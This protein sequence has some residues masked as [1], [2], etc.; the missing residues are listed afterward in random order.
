MLHVSRINSPEALAALAADWN[1]LA[2]GHPFR[3]H[4][5]HATWWQHYA[6]GRR[7][8]FV[9]VVRDDRGTVVGIAPWCIDPSTT[10]GR[11]ITWLGSGEVCS[12]YQSLLVSPDHVEGVTDAIAEWL[13]SAAN[14]AAGDRWDL[15]QLD[16]VEAID[17]AVARLVSHLWSSGS[18]VYREAG[19]NCWRIELPS[20]WDEYVEALS[21]SHRKQL[22]RLESRDL[23]T[24]RAVL[25]TASDAG[26]L[27]R[28]MNILIDLHQRRRTS[29]GQP[30][31]F[32]SQPFT[33]FLHD[34]A[35]RLFATNMLRLHWL[36]IAGVPAAAEF[37]LAGGAVTYAYQAG[38]N[39]DLLDDEPGRL[40][41][42]ATLRH[43]I[44]EGCTGFDFLRGD[45]PYKAHWRALAC[46]TVVYRIVP[47]RT[48]SQIR[49]GV[50]LAGDSV[51]SWV[52][53]GLELTGMR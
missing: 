37:Q 28:G 19:S 27:A 22:R 45:E 38:V 39:P 23:Q 24:G 20:S 15:L 6:D 30:G 51:K 52:K 2:G 18:T 36:E 10:R 41:N 48:L 16:A 1:R 21:K 7:E 33:N 14:S 47:Q 12:D 11:V 17:E 53:T 3:R 43:A 50:W 40:I 34:A 8:K 31:C 42:I 29:L 13:L 32:A 44:D 5:W 46:E 49:H 9:L 25:H 35:T 4:E 26:S